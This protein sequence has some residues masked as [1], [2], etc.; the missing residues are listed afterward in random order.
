[1]VTANI[2]LDSFERFYHGLVDRLPSILTAL[3]VFLAFY[4]LSRLVRSGARKTFS[5]LSTTAHVDV[6]VS[7]LLSYLT[8]CIGTV[9]ALGVLGINM[10]T[11]I[12]S[13]GLVSV[14][15]GFAMKDVV[16]N[17]LAGFVIILQKPYLV[18]DSIAV[19][20]LE[21]KVEDIRIRDTVLRRPDGRLVFVP[22]NNI[23][24]S[25]VT[26]NTASGHRR[27]EFV[28]PLPPRADAQEAVDLALK[29]LSGLRGTLSDPAAVA[30]VEGVEDGRLLL[31]VVYWTDLDTDAFTVKTRAFLALNKALAGAGF[32]TCGSAP[33]EGPSGAPQAPPDEGGREVG[34]VGGE[35]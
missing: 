9:V 6:L 15:L 17:F 23:F 10:G 13:L 21:G 30:G 14:G 12:A 31:K 8:L 1:M 35:A 24:C 22:N 26:N 18:G 25:A 34:E 7:R 32:D 33:R 5:R 20:D 28:L 16:G 11:L 3:A 2:A 29:T 19:G 27:D 4:L